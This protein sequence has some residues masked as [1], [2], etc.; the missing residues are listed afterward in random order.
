VA[1]QCING[2]EG[3]IA[4][5]S[6]NITGKS[7]ECRPEVTSCVLMRV[8]VPILETQF[9]IRG[10][11]GEIIELSDGEAEK[12]S[13]QLPFCTVKSGST[14][15]HLDRYAVRFKRRISL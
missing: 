9:S 15:L 8:N 3:R 10:C 7:V 6:F 14:H 5:H 13:Q 2:F 12:H 1:L 4:G 11:A